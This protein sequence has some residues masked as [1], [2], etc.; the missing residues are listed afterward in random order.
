MPSP[1]LV[2]SVAGLGIDGQPGPM[3]LGGNLY[4]LLNGGASSGFI[5]Y[6]STDAGLTWARKDEA[7]E[8]TGTDLTGWAG[9]DDGSGV[10]Y[11]AYPNASFELVY[12]AFN[13]STGTWGSVV[14][15]GNTSI[16]VYVCAYRS[17]DTALIVCLKESDSFPQLQYCIATI[18]GSAS[19]L[20]DCSNNAVGSYTTCWAILQGIGPEVFFVFNQTPVTAGTQFL[21]VQELAGTSLGSVVDIASGAAAG[22]VDIYGFASGFSDG[23]N[24]AIAWI[25]NDTFPV[26]QVMEA[27]TSTMVFVSKL[28]TAPDSA[29]PKQIGV[30]VSPG[31][32]TLLFVSEESSDALVFVTDTG[33]GFGAFTTLVPGPFAGTDVVA[34]VLVS[35]SASGWAIVFDMG[36]SVYYLAG[37]AAAVV[38]SVA[39]YG[40]VGTVVL[41]SSGSL[42]RYAQPIACRK[43]PYRT[44]LTA[45]PLVYGVKVGN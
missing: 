2:S 10:I 19:G 6:E 25:P 29:T 28:A 22:S 7:G 41:P 39:Y 8:P 27:P 17:S 18:G 40:G 42:C 12:A 4:A 1:S 44:I 5:V 26:I 34:N 24:V 37:I 15:T 38:S 23:S 11:V 31:L 35:G 3:Q 43:Q 32:G 14:S 33:S 30:L 45:G 16:A 9:C 21:Q 20:A 36:G 13:T